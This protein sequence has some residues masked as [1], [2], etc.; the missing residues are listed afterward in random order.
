M[1]TESSVTIR[2]G[3]PYPQART[4]C[5]L[6]GVIIAERAPVELYWLGRPVSAEKALA[7]DPL[8]PLVRGLALAGV[9]VV[10]EVGEAAV[11]LGEIDNRE[12]RG[13]VAE[14][15]VKELAER[16]SSASTG[17]GPEG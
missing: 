7:I 13:I 11:R 14:R 10:A 8:P 2:L 3:R 17:G 5:T 1:W 12:L 15:I 6:S 4:R 9:D 16:W